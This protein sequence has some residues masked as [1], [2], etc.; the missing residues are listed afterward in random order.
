M[1]KKLSFVLAWV[2]T[3]TTFLTACSGGNSE[4]V[5]EPPKELSGELTI[6]KIDNVDPFVQTITKVYPNVKVNV[7]DFNIEQF[8]KK[9]K[10]VIEAGTGGPD[11]VYLSPYWVASNNMSSDLENLLDPPYNA[12]QL[13]DLYPEASWNSYQSL[14]GKKMFS[15]PL[16]VEPEMTIYRSDILEE[17]GFPSDPKELAE[18]MSTPENFLDMALALKA[19]GIYLLEDNRTIMDLYLTGGGSMFDRNLNFTLN[20]DKYA[21]GLRLV[22]QVKQLGLALNQRLWTDQGKLALAAGKLAMLFIG[23]SSLDF[24]IK[25]KAPDSVG[26]WK[27]THLP[28]GKAWAGNGNLSFAILSQSK[29]KELAWECI[30]IMQASDE[31]AKNY[32]AA[33]GHPAYKPAWS[34]PEFKAF[35]TL[36]TGDQKV[37][38]IMA[39]AAAQSSTNEPIYYIPLS[40]KVWEIWNNGIVEAIE[41]NKDPKAAIQ[42]IA[43][44]FQ[45]AAKPEIEKLKAE[46][47]IQ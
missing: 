36:A 44:D 15:L 46:Y 19:K 33:G 7:Q 37:N 18:Y 5:P 4:P 13:K 21:E 29:N 47:G 34:F 38:E 25:N 26:K 39:E 6:W 31:G 24:I 30:K 12:S 10:E 2:L 35:T 11:L 23:T 8:G 3:L 1:K 45:K 9:L 22:Q 14:D 32:I 16:T 40:P 41:K 20:T 42:Q 17:N 43:N 27:V 28:F